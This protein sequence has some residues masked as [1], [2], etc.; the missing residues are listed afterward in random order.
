MLYISE[1]LPN[2][3]G[4]DA[5]GEWVELGNSG[6][7]S[8]SL[9]GWTI[10][11]GGEKHYALSGSVDSRGFLL[12]RREEAKFTL[13]N[14]DGELLLYDKQGSIADR[15]SF[16]GT[17]PEGKSA[18]REGATLLFGVPTPGARNAEML[19]SELI[20]DTQNVGSFIKQGLG[21]GDV[22]F[23][24]FGVGIALAVGALYILKHNGN[25]SHSFF[26]GN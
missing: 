13:K 25:I 19:S 12:V 10:G 14:T 16:L 8:V 9:K 17:A 6:T 22:A 3:A 18:N 26:G 4:N 15:V 20:Q 1:W 23:A 7:A 24:A 5:Q 11:T 21:V 2:P